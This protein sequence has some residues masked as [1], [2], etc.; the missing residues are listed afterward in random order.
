MSS[1]GLEV[2]EDLPRILD[3][4]RR[5]AQAAELFEQL[6]RCP[7]AEGVALGVQVMKVFF[8]LRM[9]VV[10]WYYTYPPNRCF[11]CPCAGE[12]L[13]VWGPSSKRDL[14]SGPMT[15]TKCTPSWMAGHVFVG[16]DAG[17]YDG[18]R[19]LNT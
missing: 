5:L 3:D 18:L 2:F 6:K 10:L 7:W 4:P 11:D 14:K 19:M 8:W 15:T 1:T 9:V 12:F 16:A 13:S 17:G